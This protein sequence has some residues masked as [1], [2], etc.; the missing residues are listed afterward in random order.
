MEP[1]KDI[2]PGADAFAKAEGSTVG[3]DIESI[4][5]SPSQR[6]MLSTRSLPTCQSELRSCTVIRQ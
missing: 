4:P 5:F 2:I 3:C 6:Q 1:R